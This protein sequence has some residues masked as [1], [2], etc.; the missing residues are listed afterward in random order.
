MHFYVPMLNFGTD[1]CF[2]VRQGKGFRENRNA[3]SL[4]NCFITSTTKKAIILALTNINPPEFTLIH[5]FRNE[6]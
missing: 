1:K 2:L 6:Q 3:L 5:E 4:S